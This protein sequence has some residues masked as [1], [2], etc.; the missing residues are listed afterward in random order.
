M[1]QIVLVDHTFVINFVSLKFAGCSRNVC[2]T[3][4]VAMYTITALTCFS[5]IANISYD[6]SVHRP[7]LQH[8]I[9]VTLNI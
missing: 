9:N 7:T 5:C 2:T 4:K 3:D 6:E 1:Y 8:F